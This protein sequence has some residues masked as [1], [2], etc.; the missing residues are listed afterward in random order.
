MSQDEL[1]ALRQ[2]ILNDLLPLVADGVDSSVDKFSV[3]LRIIQAG[4]AGADIYRQ[5]YDGALSFDDK[6]AKLDALMALLDEIDFSLQDREQLD[7]AGVELT[8]DE[9]ESQ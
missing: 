3:L 7:D 9:A 4:G 1:I 6:D 2:Q 5:A 8:D